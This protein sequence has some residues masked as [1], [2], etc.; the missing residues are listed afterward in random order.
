MN[1]KREWIITLVCALA[2]LANSAGVLA[3]EG[4]PSTFTRRAGGGAFTGSVHAWNQEGGAHFV[5]EGGAHFVLEGQAGDTFVFA[6]S[7]FGGKVVKGA[8]Y[9]AEAVTE[10][11]Q[12]LADGNR[13]VRKS[14]ASIYRDSE[15]RTRREQSVRAIGPGLN[16]QSG[17]EMQTVFINDPVAET[18]YVLNPQKRTARKMPLLRAKMRLVEETMKAAREHKEALAARRPEMQEKR[19]K[20]IAELHEKIKAEGTH[21]EVITTESG[22]A[23]FTASVRGEAAKNARTESL[24]KQMFDGVEAE[25]TRTT[26]TIAAGEI[27]NEFPIEI[28][29]ERWYSPELQVSVMTRHSDPR[30]G[31]NTYRL[32]N[33][34]RNEPARSLFEV[35]GDYTIEEAK[36][37]VGVG[38]IMRRKKPEN[39]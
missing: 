2:L 24:G 27:G 12:V 31:E 3:Q 16:V 5:Q 23:T 17:E 29:H 35:P 39:Q 28:V 13:I 7:E 25:G 20:E 22:N 38:G 14:S 21:V 32:T 9:S 6:S 36:G 37:G 4:R 33:I 15:G 19:E 1:I 34:N 11:I 10:H 18:N 30:S 8:P 26:I